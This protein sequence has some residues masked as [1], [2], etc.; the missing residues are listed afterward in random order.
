MK[1]VNM[2]INNGNEIIICINYLI[3]KYNLKSMETIINKT[4]NCV[5]IK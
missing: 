5:E 2:L 1:Q 3:N 4:N